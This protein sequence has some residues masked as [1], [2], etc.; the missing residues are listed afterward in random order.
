MYGE[1]DYM[2][3]SLDSSAMHTRYGH[4]FAWFRYSTKQ[5]VVN[6]PRVLSDLR[7]AVEPQNVVDRMK[8]QLN[9][10][11]RQLSMVSLFATLQLKM[12]D[13]IPTMPADRQRIID[14]AQARVLEQQHVVDDLQRKVDAEANA[15]YAESRARIIDILGSAFRMG[16]AHPLL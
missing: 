6:D 12:A 9:A 13:A 1:W 14:K 5:Y 7:R 8:D 10:E 11:K 3:D 2:T 15:S 16:V 4:E